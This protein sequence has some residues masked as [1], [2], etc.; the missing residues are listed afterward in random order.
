MSLS[1]ISLRD[2][3]SISSSLSK[4]WAYGAL[5]SEHSR[6]L[7]M[8]SN[9]FNKVRCGSTKELINAH[10]TI[11]SDSNIDDIPINMSIVSMKPSPLIK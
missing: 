10:R 4:K 2:S 11:E 8:K 3:V 7:Q 9:N 5:V 1:K 6:L